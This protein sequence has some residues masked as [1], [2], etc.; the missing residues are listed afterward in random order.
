[1]ISVFAGFIASGDPVVE[2]MGVGLATAVAV[3][4]TIVRM[5]L[6]PSTMA[7]IGDPNR[8]LPA[9]LDGVLPTLDIEGDADLAV[10]VSTVCSGVTP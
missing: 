3:A 9:W 7:L 10:P 8:W 2:M 6:A 5:V 1:M 4:A